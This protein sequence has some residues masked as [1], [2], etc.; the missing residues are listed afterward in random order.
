MELINI[1]KRCPKC[2]HKID[3]IYLYNDLIPQVR[4]ICNNCNSK[5]EYE[6]YDNENGLLTPSIISK[7]TLLKCIDDWFKK[8]RKERKDE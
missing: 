6:V 5:Y 4:I 1:N 8:M 3:T 2:N 7:D